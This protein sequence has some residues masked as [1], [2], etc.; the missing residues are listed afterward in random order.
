MNRRGSGRFSLVR[1]RVLSLGEYSTYNSLSGFGQ[2]LEERTALD[3]F[4]REAYSIVPGFARRR[5]KLKSLLATSVGVFLSYSAFPQAPPPWVGK[6]EETLSLLRSGNLPAA[7]EAFE[8]LWRANTHWRTQSAR[9]WTRRVTIRKLQSGTK[10]PSSSTRSL[11]L[12]ITT[13]G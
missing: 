11:P 9:R 8:K 6:Y 2:K 10:E 5:T 13:W 12:P 4:T 7:T 1:P 3:F